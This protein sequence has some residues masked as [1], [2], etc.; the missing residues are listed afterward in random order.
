MAETYIGDD[1]ARRD[2]N[3]WEQLE[4]GCTG[5]TTGWDLGMAE[6]GDTIAYARPD[7]PLHGSEDWPLVGPQPPS[8]LSG[9]GEW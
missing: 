6:Y 7:C 3:S 4:S 9:R 2:A 1:S 5:C 8:Q